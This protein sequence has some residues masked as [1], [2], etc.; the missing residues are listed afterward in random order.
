MLSHLLKGSANVTVSTGN[1]LN[2]SDLRKKAG[3]K[4]TDEVSAANHA[5]K[6]TNICRGVCISRNIL[7]AYYTNKV[8]IDPLKIV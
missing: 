7:R 2:V 8:K 1:V 6:S 4:P 3:Q 5:S